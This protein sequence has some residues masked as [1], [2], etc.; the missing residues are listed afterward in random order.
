MMG[1]PAWMSGIIMSCANGAGQ[2]TRCHDRE[3]EGEGVRKCWTEDEEG[4]HKVVIPSSRW[5]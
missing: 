5:L 4:V 3:R 2:S 1:Q